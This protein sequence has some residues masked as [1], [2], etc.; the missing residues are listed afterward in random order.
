M[1]VAVCVI[2]ESRL[3]TSMLMVS[4]IPVSVFT[5]VAFRSV[6]SADTSERISAAVWVILESKLETLNVRVSILALIVEILE[7]VLSSNP[8]RS[9]LN[10]VKVSLM[11][12]RLV[13]MSFRMPFSTVVIFSLNRPSR[14]DTS[15]RISVAV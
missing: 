12:A 11:E 13:A 7:F 1:D 10:P 6:T 15:L 2:L 5:M 14:S 3:A 9:L 4:R 8:E